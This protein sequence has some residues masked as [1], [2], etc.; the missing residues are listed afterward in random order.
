MMNT[1]LLKPLKKTNATVFKAVIKSKTF[2]LFS[3]LV[4]YKDNELFRLRKCLVFLFHG[5]NPLE[6]RVSVN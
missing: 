6:A 4:M 1:L 3:G 2:D 5:L